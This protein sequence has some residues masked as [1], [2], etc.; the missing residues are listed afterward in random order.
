MDMV[1]VR[2]SQRQL[3]IHEGVSAIETISCLPGHRTH[4]VLH[5]V[6]HCSQDLHDMILDLLPIT[7]IMTAL[8]WYA[9]RLQGVGTLDMAL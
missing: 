1:F 8:R 7:G 3:F 4:L 2:H 5:I 9:Q 6:S